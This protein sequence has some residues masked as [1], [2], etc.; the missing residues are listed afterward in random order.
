MKTLIIAS[1]LLIHLIPIVF[2]AAPTHSIPLLNS[3]Y[4]TNT[5]LENITVYNVSTA[6]IDNDPVKNII[7]WYRNDTNI[8]FQYTPFEGGSTATT[9][10]DYGPTA[11][12][13]VSGAT[14]ANNSGY[15]GFGAY[16]FDGFND[17]IGVGKPFKMTNQLFSISAWMKS[18]YSKNQTIYERGGSSLGFMLSIF[19]SNA[20]FGYRTSAGTGGLT[21]ITGGIINDNN[22]HH[23][24]ATI[25]ASGN[26]V[27]Y[28]DG[29][30]VATGARSLAGSDPAEGASIGHS[31]NTFVVPAGTARFNGTIDDLIIFGIELSPEQVK[32]IYDNRTDVIH[33]TLL[34]VND[35]WN[36]SITPND[37]SQ[38]GTTSF[39]TAL[40]LVANQEPTVN[41][42]LFNVSTLTEETGIRVNTTYF[43]NQ[44]HAGTV[45]FEWYVNGSSIFTQ[46]F[47]GIAN[48][49]EIN[50]TITNTLFIRGD[51]VNVTVN[52]SDLFS[53]SATLNSSTLTVANTLPHSEIPVFNISTLTEESGIQVNSTYRDADGDPGKL[54]FEWWRNGSSVQTNN[55]SVNNAA[56]GTATLANT[57]FIKGDEINVTVYAN[58]GTGSEA[59]VLG[60]ATL[61]VANTLPL[62][63][64]PVFNGTNITIN[65]GIG[66][67]TTIH[68]IDNDLL[69]VN[70][71]WFVNGSSVFTQNFT[72]IPV[73][74]LVNTTLSNS[75]YAAGDNLNVTVYANDGVGNSAVLAS[76]V[77]IVQN[78]TV[79]AA[80]IDIANTT[81]ITVTPSTVQ[82]GNLTNFNVTYNV[83]GSSNATGANI[84]LFIDG[85]HIQGTS[86]TIEN[87]TNVQIELNWSTATVGNHTILYSGDSNDTFAETNETN[88]NITINLEVS[89]VI[90]PIVGGISP[91]SVTSDETNSFS[92]S[93]SDN[94]GV[95]SCNLYVN[96]ADQG[97]MTILSGTATK[98]ATL[99]SASDTVLDV[100]A[101]CTDAAGNRVSNSTNVTVATVRSGG[102]SVG[103]SAAAEASTGEGANSLSNAKRYS[104]V[105]PGQT[106]P[107]RANGKDY[108]I[109]VSSIY[110]NSVR[111]DIGGMYSAILLKDVTKSFDMN[112]DGIGDITVYID[113]VVSYS[114]A[115]VSIREEEPEGVG[116]LTSFFDL[117]AVWEKVMQ[118][119]EEK[120]QD[121][122]DENALS[123]EIGR[124]QKELKEKGNAIT[125]LETEIARLL[126]MLNKKSQDEEEGP[127]YKNIEQLQQQVEQLKN[128]YAV[129][130]DTTATHINGAID[131]SAENVI[132]ETAIRNIE[133][134]STQS[135]NGG[136][137]FR[138]ALSWFVTVGGATG[139]TVKE[140]SEE[141]IIT[142]IPRTTEQKVIALSAVLVFIIFPLCLGSFYVHRLKER[143]IKDITNTLQGEINKEGISRLVVERNKK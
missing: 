61:T 137:V 16:D 123:Q 86:I 116:S 9:T 70:F 2:A 65:S 94:V 103:G 74:T 23:L 80:T 73:D 83:T 125:T 50:S 56:I 120:A 35:V 82:P 87:G 44:S 127:L 1:F 27:L 11:I 93:V 118:N 51:L 3:T 113:D 31:L 112:N 75:L 18:G 32:L 49:T 41:P 6:D 133:I 52:A 48:N 138:E 66:A 95:S 58:D 43:D 134:S 115:T 141:A 10:P 7:Q 92:A 4:G 13:N 143:K 67:N 136:E 129:L 119:K 101:N 72:A 106:I 117:G 28:V 19:N 30:S 96:G 124:L 57:N 69:N 81:G 104:G 140:Y 131:N 34:A 12:W 110:P 39:S 45:R 111:L 15:D 142:N 26:M 8:L 22:W 68:D 38:D 84:S 78:L 105:G 59:I 108:K 130:K 135:I 62:V 98:S 53:D 46:N 128:E 63:E 97:V 60:S 100:H 14:W 29:A 139:A 25:N 126:G 76:T 109:T 5:S 99:S 21:Q 47:T 64:T 102:N 24:V 122:N 114:K 17:D 20:S 40:T 79:V 121:V 55:V 54:Y 88:Q 91:I 89:D 90:G 37:G 42:P 132:D 36:A 107:V 71:E 77:I 85:N 33:S